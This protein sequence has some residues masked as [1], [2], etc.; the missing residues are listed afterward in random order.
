MSGLMH[1]A[2][3]EGIVQGVVVHITNEIDSGLD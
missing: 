2:T 3:F 1:T